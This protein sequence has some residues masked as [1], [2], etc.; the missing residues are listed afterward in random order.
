MSC[1][2]TGSGQD[3]RHERDPEDR[4]AVLLTTLITVLFLGVSS[5]VFWLA[6]G[7]D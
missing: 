7:V 4:D 2:S 1:Y 5:T 6:I 3:E